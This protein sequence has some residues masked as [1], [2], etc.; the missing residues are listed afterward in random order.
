MY[1]NKNFKS[2]HNFL[3]STLVTLLFWYSQSYGDDY[4]IKGKTIL[5][6]GDLVHKENGTRSAFVSNSNLGFNNIFSNLKIEQKNTFINSIFIETLPK[7]EEAI[8]ITQDSTI[9]SI[10]GHP[11]KITLLK[12]SRLALTGNNFDGIQEIQMKGIDNA[13]YFKDSLEFKGGIVG[14]DTGNI[15]AKNASFYGSID[16]IEDIFLEGNDNFINNNVVGNSIVLNKNANLTIDSSNRDID[17]DINIVV[18]NENNLTFRGKNDIYLRGDLGNDKT[19]FESIKIENDSHIVGNVYSKNILLIGDTSSLTCTECHIYSNIVTDSR[20]SN[21][22]LNDKTSIYGNIGS[23]ELPLKAISYFGNQLKIIGDIFVQNIV[24]MNNDSDIELQGNVISNVNFNKKNNTNL[25]IGENFQGNIINNNNSNIIINKQLDFSGNFGEEDNYIRDIVFSIADENKIKGKMYVKN[26]K[27]NKT[28]NLSILGDTIMNVSNPINISDTQNITL[29]VY[30]GGNQFSAYFNDNYSNTTININNDTQI[31]NYFNSKI[32][33]GALNIR[34]N[35]PNKFVNDI[36]AEQINLNNALVYFGG[37]VTSGRLNLADE[38]IIMITSDYHPLTF[39]GA[40]KINN[41]KKNILILQNVKNITFTGKIGDAS[42]FFDTMKIIDTNITLSN[43]GFFNNIFFEENSQLILD[44]NQSLTVT[45]AIPKNN[46]GVVIFKEGSVFNG[47]LGKEGCN[48]K[49]IVFNTSR[50]VE[51][52]IYSNDTTIKQNISFES[53]VLKTPLTLDADVKVIIH[54]DVDFTGEISTLTSH[55]GSIYFINREFI[56]QSIGQRQ[57][58]LKLVKIKSKNEKTSLDSDIFSDTTHINA[59]LY[60]MRSIAIDGNLKIKNSN[61]FLSDNSLNVSKRLSLEGNIILNSTIMADKYGYINT[62]DLDICDLSKME[63]NIDNHM[64][65]NILK[66]NKFKIINI[67]QNANGNF[68]NVILKSNDNI[69]WTFNNGEIIAANAPD[70]IQE[71]D[72]CKKEV[73]IK[74]VVCE[75]DSCKEEVEIKQVVCEEDSCKEAVQE[76]I[77]LKENKIS[78]VNEDKRKDY[79]KKSEIIASATSVES[80]ASDKMEQKVLGIGSNIRENDIKETIK[81]NVLQKQIV[82]TFKN[83]KLAISLQRIKESIVENLIS[84]RLENISIGVSAGDEPKNI[85]LWIQ[86]TKGIA[87][88]KKVDDSPG[89]KA[90]INGVIAGVDHLFD[91]GS[92]LGIS[93]GYLKSKTKYQDEGLGD[94]SKNQGGMIIGYGNYNIDNYWVVKGIV[95]CGKSRIHNYDYRFQFGRDQSVSSKFNSKFFNVKTE[96]NHKIR[97]KRFNLIPIFG[98]S[99]LNIRDDSYS[100]VGNSLSSMIVDKK[101]NYKLNSILGL[102]INTDMTINEVNFTPEIHYC[103]HN[104]FKQS[105]LKISTIL[106]GIVTHYFPESDYKVDKSNH[107]FGTTLYVK[108]KNITSGLSIN[109]IRANKFKAYQTTLKV[110]VDF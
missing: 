17:I 96:I 7:N 25:T 91:N 23:L 75:E 12:N 4:S 54:K 39:A 63:I 85:G 66:N 34:N 79:Y 101:F 22:N 104:T 48:F 31:P 60:V 19:I 89:Y 59:N 64:G 42:D 107:Q 6:N 52:N 21:M 88:Q 47:A 33:T 73:E 58:N 71:E 106:D 87:R 43:D 98:V 28:L 103:W 86:G 83:V 94:T 29:N 78:I 61:I 37:N 1:I 50:S 95:S 11:I 69:N 14:D 44:K 41:R 45:N 62:Q 84:T 35:G 15:Y 77:I 74:Q 99:Y 82:S 26:I 49:Q 24:F 105:K 3:S 110:K 65:N 68:N 40:I 13:I 46:Q 55:Q 80:T 8:I 108:N 102:R 72:S 57:N 38:N 36:V 2:Q 18:K 10:T 32:Y 30:G 53:G 90:V 93:G 9:N 56:N 67:G 27:F 20:F 100:E 16:S 109:M 70:L 76:R 81:K 51:N 92:I 5:R 97:T